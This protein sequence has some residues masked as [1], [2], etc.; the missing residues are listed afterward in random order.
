VSVTRVF[1]RRLS[2]KEILDYVNDHQVTRYA[3]GYTPLNSSAIGFIEKIEGSLTGFSHGLPLEQVLP[4]I[5]E[6]I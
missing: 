1:F 4:I 3:A 2:E 6:A 5:S